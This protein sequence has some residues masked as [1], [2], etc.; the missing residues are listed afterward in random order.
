MRITTLL[1]PGVLSFSICLSVSAQDMQPSKGSPAKTDTGSVSKTKPSPAKAGS[2]KKTKVKQGVN[3]TKVTPP[4][5][6]VKGAPTTEQPTGTGGE[7]GNTTSAIPEVKGSTA[8]VQQTK[9]GS[10]NWTQQYIT[11]KGQSVLDTV[12]WKNAAQARMMATRG[13]VVVAQRNLLE[14]VKGVEVTGETT[15]QDMIATNDNVYTR[16]DGVVKGAQQVGEAIMKD[17][18]V[19]VTM[20]MPIYETNGLAAAV[21]DNLPVAKEGAGTAGRGENTAARGVATDDAGVEDLAKIAFNMAGKKINPSMFPLI[22]DEKGH[23]VFDFSKIY[24]PKSG[25][26]PKIVQ[27]TKEVLNQAGYKDAVKVLDVLDSK[28]GKIIISDVAAKKVNWSKIGKTAATIGKFL[29]MLI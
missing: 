29:M 27:A 23:V 13:A 24:D 4:P 6:V 3:Q 26:F 11:A 14:I 25:K 20:R 5:T 18:M 22:V 16:V 2:V 17:G 7:H 28:D 10:V 9:N 19:E 8:V 15:V 21:Y 1:L 12:R